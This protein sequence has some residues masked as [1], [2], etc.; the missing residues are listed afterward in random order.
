VT[1]NLT[2]VVAAYAVMWAVLIAY[3]LRLRAL[4]KRSREALAHARPTRGAT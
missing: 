4:L 1:S 3:S 2:F